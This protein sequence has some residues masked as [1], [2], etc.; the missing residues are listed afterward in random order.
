MAVKTN[1]DKTVTTMYL[2][3]AA[4]AQGNSE[5]TKPL[6]AGLCDGPECAGVETTAKRLSQPW[7]VGR[8]RLGTILQREK[9]PVDSR[10]GH[11]PRRGPGPLLG[12]QAT[13][14]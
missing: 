13:G 11:R 1:C 12:A 10:S 4:G 8:G 14:N 7:P 9:S 2:L 3:I 5:G 6:G